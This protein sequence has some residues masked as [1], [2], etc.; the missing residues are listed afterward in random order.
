M[1]IVSFKPYVSGV[2]LASVS[3]PGVDVIVTDVIAGSRP[4]RL[5][6]SS[7]EKAATSP[8]VVFSGFVAGLA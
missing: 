2:P 6:T 4:V 3:T 7:S 8:A 5:S 1:S